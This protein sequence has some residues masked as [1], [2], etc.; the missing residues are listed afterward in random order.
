MSTTTNRRLALARFA[1]V[2]AAGLLAAPASLF[3]STVE[4]HLAWHAEMIALRDL[5]DGPERPGLTEE[6][7][8]AE[9]DRLHELYDLISTTPAETMA[10]VQEQLRVAHYCAKTWKGDRNEPVEDALQHAIATI[11][12]LASRRAAA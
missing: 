2:S 4:P 6:D 9:Y 7:E 11:E 10:G 12:R 5:L 8:E 3:A 1:G